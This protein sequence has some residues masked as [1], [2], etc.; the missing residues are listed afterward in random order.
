ML[1]QMMIVLL[2]LI[3]AGYVTW[4]LLSMTSR[5]RLLD[6]LAR[7][8]L[9]VQAAQRHRARLAAPGCGNCA[10]AG[11]HLVTQSRDAG[12]AVKTGVKT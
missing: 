2:V 10:A 12:K 7:R 9:L 8:G 4:S 5:Q 6:A 3:A 1:Q 11:Q